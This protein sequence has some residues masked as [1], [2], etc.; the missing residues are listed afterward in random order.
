MERS[1][2]D[3]SC[4]QPHPICWE[5]WVL[6]GGR[7]GPYCQLNFSLYTS[8]LAQA[9]CMLSVIVAVFLLTNLL[10]Q[11]YDKIDQYGE[12]IQ[13]KLSTF[14][15]VLSNIKS[16]WIAD[17]LDGGANVL[18]HAVSEDWGET[19][20]QAIIKIQPKR[21]F[22]GVIWSLCQLGKVQEMSISLSFLSFASAEHKEL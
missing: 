9:D 15:S 10:C 16:R 17:N 19:T 22:M 18:C 1:A 3:R 13:W 11:F 4:E 12:Q 5:A 14:H 20:R 8:T 7:W 6:A 2:L 21:I